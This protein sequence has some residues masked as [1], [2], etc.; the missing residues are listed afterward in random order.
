M[1]T[2]GPKTRTRIIEA[3]YAMFYAQGY[4]RVSVDM[5]AA[6]AGITKRTL[7]AHF[8][9]KDDLAGAACEHAMTLANK[10]IEQW[11]HKIHADPASG[12]E[13]VFEEL[14]AWCRQRKFAGAGF[15]RIVLEL[16][17][18]P[19][20]PVRRVAEAH[21]S[22]IEAVLA[23]ALGST[24][25]S[26]ALMIILEGTMILTLTTRRF[27]H[28]AV[29]RSLARELVGHTSPSPRHVAATRVSLRQ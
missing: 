13:H 18:L 23:D 9:S 4:S 22:R 8:P 26:R 17:D 1:R 6:K 14:E 20:H 19:G 28:L 3:A 15:T 27:D 2:S 11:A 24:R 12:I 25:L 29:G 21:K 10:R 16:A 7:Y 5:I